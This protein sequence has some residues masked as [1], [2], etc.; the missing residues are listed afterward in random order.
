[1]TVYDFLDKN[2]ES[3]KDFIKIGAVS[4]TWMH[5]YNI[6]CVYRNSTNIKSK[7]NRLYF[8][9][10]VCKVS[11]QTVRIALQCMNKKV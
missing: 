10:E 6:F 3:L 1:M 11:T 5:Y 4:P 2:L 8:T 9:S 7:M